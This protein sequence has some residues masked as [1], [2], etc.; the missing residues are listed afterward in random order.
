MSPAFVN[1]VNLAIER[2]MVISGA[3]HS[4]CWVIHKKTRMGKVREGGTGHKQCTHLTNV[5]EEE[6]EDGL[7]SRHLPEDLFHR[8]LGL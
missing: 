7:Q 6:N 8:N 3:R 4:V 5:S 2:S 1:R